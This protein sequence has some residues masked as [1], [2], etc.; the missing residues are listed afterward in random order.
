MASKTGV[1]LPAVVLAAAAVLVVPELGTRI[2]DTVSGWI[3]GVELV[4]E[5]ETQFMVAASASSQVSRCTPQKSLEE[6]ACEDLKFVILDAAKMPFIT[7]NVSTAWKAGHPGVLTKD[8]TRQA[9]NRKKVCL[10]SFPRPYGGQCDEY[11]FASSRQGGAGSQEQ[12]VPAR[13]NQC[14]G[15]TL[16]TK[17]AAARIVDGDDY[18]V[19]ITHP[20]KIAPGPFQG[21]DIALGQSC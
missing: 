18:L 13:E 17:Y 12:E 1:L 20:D 7:R 21:I 15:G 3:G 10:P 6:K 5:G 4:G 8:S 16:S 14:Q 9:D 11:P 2:G 19:V